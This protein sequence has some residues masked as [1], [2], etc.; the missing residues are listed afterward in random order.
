MIIDMTNTGRPEGGSSE[1]PLRVTDEDLR[2]LAEYGD[3]AGLDLTPTPPKPPE[4]TLI[5]RLLA[6]QER[7]NPTDLVAEITSRTGFQ[8]HGPRLIVDH[9]PIG[10]VRRLL[11]G[12]LERYL[13]KLHLERR[14]R[15]RNE[16]AAYGTA[17]LLGE[18]AVIYAMHFEHMGGSVGVVAGENFQRAADYA[19]KEK[20]PLIGLF[21]SGGIR[22][23]ENFAGL[24]QMERMVRA[25]ARSYKARTNLPYTAVVMGAWGGISAS[26]VAIADLGIGMA[27]TDYG[28]TGPRV[29]EAY[30]GVP[31]PEGS[32][33]VENNLLDRNLDVVVK[34]VDEL[35]ALLG[36]LIKTIRQSSNRQRMNAENLPELGLLSP[37]GLAKIINFGAKGIAPAVYDRQPTV[38]SLSIPPASP[39]DSKLSPDK[40]LME[41]YESFFRS[42]CRPDSEFVIQNILSEA[43]PLYNHYI[44]GSKKIYP[45]II[46]AIGKIGHQPFLMIGDQP[47]YYKSANGEVRKIPATPGPEDFGYVQRMLEMGERLQ[48]PVV[49]LTDTLGARPTLD[50]E[51]RGQ[52]RAIA[53]TI[54]AAD[55]YKYP[56]ISLVIGALGSGGGLATTPMGDYRAMLANSMAFVAEPKSA[57]SI[58][59][60]TSEPSADQISLTLSTMSATAQDQLKLKLIDAVIPESNDPYQT[61]INIHDAIAR[62]F[63]DIS[64]HRSLRRRNGRVRGLSI[65]T[66]RLPPT[67]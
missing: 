13:E 20:L 37:A 1:Y 27:G 52:S 2:L 39:G 64:S 34:N 15:G 62:A 41:L 47:S 65:A 6:G 59:Y 45:A 21:A 18:R 66:K 56:V 12:R 60:R 51:R 11:D 30:E 8:E 49:F 58:L 22:Q 4:L 43:I 46:A 24:V 35:V 33:A 29:I 36:G 26:A 10:L 28:F 50:A 40:R 23:Q 67:E 61:A 17:T 53:K 5:Q 32:Q 16:S 31:V 44:D 19:A 54:E 14:K 57:T 42:P 63:A 7:A 48:L 25:A 55:G 3:V 9:D 38:E